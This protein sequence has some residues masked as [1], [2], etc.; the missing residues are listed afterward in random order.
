MP[1]LALA[2][3]GPAGWWRGRRVG[4][5]RDCDH[6]LPRPVPGRGIRWRLYA[7]PSP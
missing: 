2:P 5:G 7:D 1:P 3:G 6:A 4:W